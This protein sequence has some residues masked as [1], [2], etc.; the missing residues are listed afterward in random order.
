[1]NWEA[2]GVL[3]TGVPGD[4]IERVDCPE[5]GSAPRFD[6]DMAAAIHVANNGFPYV[7]Y[8][9]PQNGRW[10]VTAYPALSDA[11]AALHEEEVYAFV[12]DGRHEIPLDGVPGGNGY[13]APES[14]L[15]KP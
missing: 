4:D 14:A 3:W 8:A 15:V 11:L 9:M 7:L 6:G 12:F 10:I 2:H 13:F 1:M 5:D